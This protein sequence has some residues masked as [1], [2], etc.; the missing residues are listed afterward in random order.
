MTKSMTKADLRLPL[1][2]SLALLLPSALLLFSACEVATDNPLGSDLDDRDGMDVQTLI[3]EPDAAW[4][5]T[6]YYGYGNTEGRI[7]LAVGRTGDTVVRNLIGFDL[8]QLPDEVDADSLY[9]AQFEYFYSRGFNIANWRPISRGELRVSIHPLESQWESDQTTWT[10]RKETRDWNQAGGDFG[11]AMATLLLEE[12]ES[13]TAETRSCDVTSLVTEWLADENAYHGL[14]LKA[15]DEAT[16]ACVKEFYSDDLQTAENRPHLVITYEGSDGEKREARIEA[17][18]DCT[19][20]HNISD[21]GDGAVYGDAGTLCLGTAFGSSRRLLFD[22]DISALPADATINL[23]QLEIYTE[24]PGRV[25]EET[26]AL[27]HPV[28][29]FDEN[30]TQSELRDLDY[31]EDDEYVTRIL[32]GDAQGVYDFQISPIV[33]DWLA[34]DYDQ[35]GVLLKIDSDSTYTEPIRIHTADCGDPDRAPRLVI[36]Y[37]QPPEHWDNQ[38]P[39]ML[40]AGE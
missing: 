32:F 29:N 37:T 3:I 26:L 24:F 34:G 14:L 30:S 10:A 5:D 16:A 4:V 1:I 15:E 9:R 8:S 36:K 19:I 17:V 2:K 11:P 22:F 23:A 21:G 7:T 13:G 40:G 35:H 31:E 6:G 18:Q 33:Q 12:I 27:H 25:Y 39:T 20:A 28:S 38:S